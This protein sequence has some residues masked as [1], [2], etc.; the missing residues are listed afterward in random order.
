MKNADMPVMPVITE[1]RV[2]NTSVSTCEFVGLTKREMFA[3][4]LMAAYRSQY[5]TMESKPKHVAGWA[6]EDA[7]ALLKELEK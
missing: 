7:D 3:I 5:E 1:K 4:K 2:A 6:I